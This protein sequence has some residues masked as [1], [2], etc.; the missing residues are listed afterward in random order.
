[1]S[2]APLPTGG[3][4]FLG[5]VTSVRSLMTPL[6]FEPAEPS[7]PDEPYRERAGRG[8]PPLADV[9]VPAGPGPHPSVVLI[10]GGGWVLGSRRMKPMRYLATKLVQR[11]FAVC[12]PEYRMVFRGGRLDEALDDA[13][14]AIGWWLESAERFALNPARV[15]LSGLS[16]GATLMLLA[17]DNHRDVPFSRIVPVFGVY[18][19]SQMHG[20]L[21]SLIQ[22]LLLRTHA[23]SD[24]SPLQR[25]PHP[26]PVTLLHGT[27]DT[28]V[29][30]AQAVQFRD[31]WTAA[32][33]IVELVTYEGL[34]HAFFNDA[35]SDGCI[36]ATADFLDAV[37][38]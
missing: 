22:P 13:T 27:A 32:G 30:H 20:G 38:R 18:D 8:L 6:Q 11:G 19:F 16:A 15:V 33:G 12:I 7:H 4:S 3:P 31:R 23:P 29:P 10:H 9:Y 26:S 25:A 17:A 14:R 24:V 28:L 37:A 36:A 21:G 35:R 2:T 34:P 1:M 5:I